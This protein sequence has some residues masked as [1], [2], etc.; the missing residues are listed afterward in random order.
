[1]H[2]TSVF[3]EK[4]PSNLEKQTVSA[5]KRNS[6]LE[7]YRG[8][9]LKIEKHRISHGNLNKN[10]LTKSSIFKVPIKIR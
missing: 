4:H 6:N 3:S 7:K 10:L 1:M 5:E 9:N 2:T 8:S